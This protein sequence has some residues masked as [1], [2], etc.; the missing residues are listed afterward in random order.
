MWGEGEPDFFS[1]V[2]KKKSVLS[3]LTKN[4][5][6]GMTQLEKREAIL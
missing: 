3:S 1:P 4:K 5:F 6:E 2:L